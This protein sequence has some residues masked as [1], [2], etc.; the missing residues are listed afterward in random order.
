MIAEISKRPNRIFISAFSLIAVIVMICSSSTTASSFELIIG[1]GPHG[2]FS[3]HSGK[4]LCRIFAKQAQDMTCSLSETSDPIDNLTNVQGGSLDLAL[5]DS[6]LLGESTIGQ[7]AFQYL[8]I[9]YDLLRIVT[10]LYEVPLTLIVRSDADMSSIDQLPGKRINTGAFGSPE[11]QLFEM[12]M[13]TQGWTEEMFPV[14]A[15]LSPSLSQDKLAFRQG[16][17]QVL[18]H[19]GVHPDNDLKQLMEDT[20]ASLVGFSS[21]GMVDLIIANPS[22]S[23]QDLNEFTYPSLSE[24]L[25]TFGTTMTLISSADLDDEIATSLI[26]A[27]EQNKHLLQTMH[28]ALSS[29]DIDKRPQWFGS[30]QVHKAIAK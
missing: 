9:N 26:T 30:I 1:T 19:K 11:K 22:L 8:D 15:E 7:G 10:P 14:L 16:D 3:H 21:N 23:R 28:P 12:F 2:S 4:L 20:K 17:V 25:S 5:V 27:L 18:L 13:Q 29:F 24:K 6:L